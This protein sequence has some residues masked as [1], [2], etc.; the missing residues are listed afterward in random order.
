MTAKKKT[1][2]ALL[3]RLE[4]LEARK[5]AREDFA[6]RCYGEGLEVEDMEALLEWIDAE[7]ADPEGVRRA[8]AVVFGEDP[9]PDTE[10]PQAVAWWEGVADGGPVAA[11]PWHEA[12]RFAAYFE[13]V[14][15]K[16]HTGTG[17]PWSL[18]YQTALRRLAAHARLA[19]GVA[20]AAGRLKP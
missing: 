7:E 3:A 2:A 12:E 9:D 13:A 16:A 18:D 6:A 10:D 11:L 5:T 20:R 19:A 1:R 14:G 4:A 15:R 17:A 8:F